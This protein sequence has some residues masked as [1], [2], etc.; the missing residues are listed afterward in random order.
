MMPEA[1]EARGIWLTSEPMSP[2]RN[3]RVFGEKVVEARGCK[4]EA[5]EKPAGAG[6]VNETD[7]R[8]AR[9]AEG[10]EDPAPQL[11]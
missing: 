4:G 2:E 10:A 11:I 1:G 9:L 3:A 8:Q 5:G 6:G 7:T